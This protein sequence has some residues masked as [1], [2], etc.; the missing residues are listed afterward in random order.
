MVML[1]GTDLL[2]QKT[3]WII[4]PRNK[5]HIYQ[6]CFQSPFHL[7]IGNVLLIL[8]EGSRE[9]VSDDFHTVILY[10]H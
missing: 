1:L 3:I 6:P 7:M 5:C 2:D 9:N 10:Q 8:L 4:F